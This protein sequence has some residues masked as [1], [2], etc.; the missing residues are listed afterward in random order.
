MAGGADQTGPTEETSLQGTISWE[1]VI[2]DRRVWMLLIVLVVSMT[3]L[4]PDQ[5]VALLRL[6]GF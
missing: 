2:S 6:I 5:A 3:G 1:V 4:A